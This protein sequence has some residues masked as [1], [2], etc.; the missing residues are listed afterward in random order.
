M[1]F[2]SLTLLPS[3]LRKLISSV[4]N[5][6]SF[7]N[8]TQDTEHLTLNKTQTINKKILQSVHK[9]SFNFKVLA[10][11]NNIQIQFFCIKIM[12]TDLAGL[13]FT[14]AHNVSENTIY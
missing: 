2:L 9:S 6:L 3:W 12:K 10:L 1:P 11:L 7:S 5:Y 13:V 14:D 8:N 4:Q